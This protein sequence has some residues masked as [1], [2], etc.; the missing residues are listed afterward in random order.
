MN[1]IE[2][3]VRTCNFESSARTNGILLSETYVLIWFVI[4]WLFFQQQIYSILWRTLPP[5]VYVLYISVK[6]WMN[7]KRTIPCLHK[8]FIS[9]RAVVFFLAFSYT[10]TNMEKNSHV[11]M[12]M[13]ENWYDS[14]W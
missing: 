11:E 10:Q 9:C 3:L 13:N 1:T 5:H 14:K 2:T 6:I 8:P 12:V 4:V 7:N